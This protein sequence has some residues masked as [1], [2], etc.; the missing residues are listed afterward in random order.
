M[1]ELCM[2]IQFSFGVPRTTEAAAQAARQ[3]NASLLS[4]G[5]HVLRSDEGVQQGLWCIQSDAALSCIDHGV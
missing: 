4:S 1:T 2:L 5:E 3:Y